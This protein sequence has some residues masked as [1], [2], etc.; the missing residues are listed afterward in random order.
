MKNRSNIFSVI[1]LFLTILFMVGSSG[2]VI[3]THTCNSSGLSD[4]KTEFF[5]PV[6]SDNSCCCCIETTSCN[7]DQ[8]ES[9]KRGC[10]SFSTEKLSLTDYNNTKFVNL[11][12]L[13]LPV[14]SWNYLPAT[15]DQEEISYPV[16][17]HN[18]HGGRDILRSTCQLII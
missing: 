6:S 12:V 8:N 10:C 16:E 9:L 11:S 15:I 14:L 13:I 18:K 17:I 2:A 7:N 1:S 5:S 3:V 4:Y